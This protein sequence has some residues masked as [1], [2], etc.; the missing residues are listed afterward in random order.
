MV[1]TFSAGAETDECTKGVRDMM[2][3]GIAGSGHSHVSNHKAQ[4]MTKWML[5]E[6][7]S[8]ILNCR[9]WPIK[10]PPRVHLTTRIHS[11]LEGVVKGADRWPAIFNS[12]RDHVEMIRNAENSDL[13]QPDS[14]T[15]TPNQDAHLRGLKILNGARRSVRQSRYASI[16]TRVQ[17]VAFMLHWHSTVSSPSDSAG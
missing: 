4:V 11:R 2:M 7:L 15:L 6:R 3:T 9:P 12:L 14:R 1:E 8:A 13:M 10:Q 17:Y 5:L 16:D